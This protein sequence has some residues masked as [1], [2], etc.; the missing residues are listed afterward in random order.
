MGYVNLKRHT[1]LFLPLSSF[2][3]RVGEIYDK[4][5]LN[6]WFRH[7]KHGEYLRRYIQS[8]FRL[9]TVSEHSR[10]SILSFF[11]R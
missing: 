7:R 9:I 5:L 11:R 10:Y 2:S 1:I 6:S 4:K 3:E 8:S